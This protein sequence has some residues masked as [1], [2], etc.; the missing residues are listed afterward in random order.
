MT[1]ALLAGGLERDQP[2]EIFE[3]VRE[4]STLAGFGTVR[5]DPKAHQSHR[6]GRCAL[7]RRVAGKRAAC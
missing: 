2:Q 6:R 7:R 3:R 5:D 1:I 4:V